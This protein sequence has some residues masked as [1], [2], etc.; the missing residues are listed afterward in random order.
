M[1]LWTRHSGAW[2]SEQRLRLIII[3]LDLCDERER[4]GGRK[5]TRNP[6]RIVLTLEGTISTL[7]SESSVGH[8]EWTVDCWATV[9]RKLYT[10]VFRYFVSKARCRNPASEFE[11]V[12]GT[13]LVGCLE[14]VAIVLISHKTSFH[15]VQEF[16]TTSS[17]NYH[18]LQLRILGWERDIKRW[19]L[20]EIYDNGNGFGPSG[21][22]THS[23][24]S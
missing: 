23:S 4:G 16:Y 15:S 13:Q 24:S 19:S 17:L 21:T 1:Q 9:H 2:S 5:K 11:F 18:C 3:A 10:Q 7:Q 20:G 12:F 8:N 22:H 14:N 6:W